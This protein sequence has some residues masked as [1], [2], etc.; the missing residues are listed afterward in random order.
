MNFVQ[1]YGIVSPS[2]CMAPEISLRDPLD[3][4]FVLNRKMA[5]KYYEKSLQDKM[6]NNKVTQGAE[7][8]K[9]KKELGDKEAKKQTEIEK[10]RKGEAALLKSKV[11]DRIAVEDERRQTRNRQARMTAIKILEDSNA[12]RDELKERLKKKQD[13]YDKKLN[14]QFER[15]KSNRDQIAAKQDCKAQKEAANERSIAT[16][17][18]DVEMTGTQKIAS[19]EAQLKKR[20]DTALAQ[21]EQKNRIYAQQQ[22]K[23]KKA[24]EDNLIKYVMKTQKV[25]KCRKQ[26]VKMMRLVS[27]NPDKVDHKERLQEINKMKEEQ[28]REQ[29]RKINKG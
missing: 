27:N 6:L 3:Q 12:E 20:Q 16:K 26:T 29:K 19:K 1:D 8:E 15:D 2:S 14:D 11:R 24:E 5:K 17:L 23:N 28:S 25:E 7:R 4:E 22:E 21:S 10:L 13:E 9:R 18:V